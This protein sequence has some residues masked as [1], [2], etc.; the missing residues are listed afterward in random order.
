MTDIYSMVSQGG[1]GGKKR[2]SIAKSSTCHLVNIQYPRET[3]E[4]LKLSF[5]RVEA[6]LTLARS[7]RVIDTSLVLLDISATGI[8][9]FTN[10][11]LSI[12]TAVMLNVTAPFEIM[13]RGMV[14][15]CA[16][17]DTR[18]D[19]TKLRHNF[20]AGIK[21][22]NLNEEEAKN[23]MDFIASIK[24]LRSMEA[25]NAPVAMVAGA[26]APESSE[27]P[28]VKIAEKISSEDKAGVVVGAIQEATS[29]AEPAATEP[30]AAAAPTTGEDSGNKAA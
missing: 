14:A 26:P 19:S 25:T 18:M 28:K 24:K 6:N 4:R 21:F 20:R 13:L 16:P 9:I 30:A 10:K 11:N 23:I 2:S 15:W 7:G 3:A 27:G 5:Q 29:A 8:G 17:I 22:T 1:N 12:G